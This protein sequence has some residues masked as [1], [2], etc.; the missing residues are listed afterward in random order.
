MGETQKYIT[1]L[2]ISVHHPTV[3]KF[4]QFIAQHGAQTQDH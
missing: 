3:G 1:K 4:E 2:D